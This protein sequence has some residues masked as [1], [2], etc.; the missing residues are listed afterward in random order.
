MNFGFT[1]SNTNMPNQT[2]N[3]YQSRDALMSQMGYKSIHKCTK[4]DHVHKQERE[5]F[6][7]KTI[8]MPKMVVVNAPNHPIFSANGGH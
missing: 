7:V 5:I 3:A 4:C 2:V 1:H 8:K 6:D